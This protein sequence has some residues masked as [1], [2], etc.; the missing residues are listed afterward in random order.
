MDTGIEAEC[1]A[2]VI[3]DSM[4]K[5]LVLQGFHMGAVSIGSPKPS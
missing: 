5:N 3:G 2:S 4:M 1:E